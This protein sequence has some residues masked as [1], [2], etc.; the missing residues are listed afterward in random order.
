MEPESKDKPK[1]TPRAKGRWVYESPENPIMVAAKKHQKQLQDQR[2][3]NAAAR[4]A[5]P[6]PNYI[7]YPDAFRGRVDERGNWLGGKVPKCRVCGYRLDPKDNHV[8]PGFTPKY[9][10]HDD[11]RHERQEAKQEEIR[12]SN[13]DRPVKCIGCHQV[14]RDGDDARRHDEHCCADMP[15]GRHW[16]TDYDPIVGDNDGHE[17]Y[18][19]E[20]EE[21]YCE[22]NDDGYDCD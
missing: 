15:R 8:C 19:D 11:A 13:Q 14:I 7:C 20:P 16:Y 9:V 2:Q 18:E 21:D 6:V 22:G 1:A 3:T 17:C 5:R 12:K 4:A 10:D